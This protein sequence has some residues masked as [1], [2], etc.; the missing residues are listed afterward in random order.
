MRRRP[1]DLET[2]DGAYGWVACTLE[3]LG[4]VYDLARFAAVY[5]HLQVDQVHGFPGTVV[6]EINNDVIPLCNAKLVRPGQRNGDGQQVAI[7]RYL[8]ELRVIAQCRTKK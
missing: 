8:N 5:V 6:G 4:H 3:S 1:D 2:Q 7:I